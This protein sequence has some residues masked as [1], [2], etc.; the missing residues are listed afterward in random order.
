MGRKG[1]IDRAAVI[2]AAAQLVDE[3]GPEGGAGTGTGLGPDH[4]TSGGPLGPV[5]IAY[6]SLTSVAERLDV[7]VPSLY[8]HIASLED[9]QLGIAAYSLDQITDA[10]RDAV[11]GKSGDDAVRA[12]ATV[13]R[14]YAKAHPG[15]Y[16]MV[17]ALTTL[18]H[19]ELLEKGHVFTYVIVAALSAYHLDTADA[20]HAIRAFRSMMHGFIMLEVAK[21]FGLPYDLD[22][23]YRRITELFIAGLHQQ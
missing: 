7:R 20:I 12:L 5:P 13:Y 10:I 8:N 1:R 9:L 15:C 22:E 2:E 18:D 17:N 4:P 11:I 19:P 21:G 23:T 3:V 14:S 6:L 16:V